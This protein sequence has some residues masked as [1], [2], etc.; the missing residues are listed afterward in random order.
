MQKHSK[1]LF[2]N[3]CRCQKDIGDCRIEIK[4]NFAYVVVLFV[5]MNECSEIYKRKCNSLENSN[6]TYYNKDL[7]MENVLVLCVKSY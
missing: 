1:L 4:F 3:H 2:L 7:I 5:L 6:K